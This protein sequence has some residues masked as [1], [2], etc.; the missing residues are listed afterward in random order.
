MGILYIP[1]SKPSE[2]IIPVYV[3]KNEEEAKVIQERIDQINLRDGVVSEKKKTHIIDNGT[4]LEIIKEVT[5][6]IYPVPEPIMSQ[7]PTTVYSFHRSNTQHQD[8][9]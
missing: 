4:S 3:P 2:T 8:E 5:P 9:L 7:P 6:R 1:M